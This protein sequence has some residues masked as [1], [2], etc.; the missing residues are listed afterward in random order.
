VESADGSRHRGS[1]VSRKCQDSFDRMC[2]LVSTTDGRG[3]A[4]WIM[5]MVVGVVSRVVCPTEDVVSWM[6]GGI[7]PRNA[8]WMVNFP[9]VKVLDCSIWIYADVA[10]LLFTTHIPHISKLSITS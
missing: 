1:W 6:V 5:F 7:L 9:K 4:R 10:D 3:H 8:L 2:E